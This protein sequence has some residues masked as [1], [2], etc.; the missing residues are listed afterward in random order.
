MMCRFGIKR[1]TKTISKQF[2][3][4]DMK[5]HIQTHINNCEVCMQSKPDL[6]GIKRYSLHISD[7]NP[8]DIISFDLVRKLP[9]SRE[10]SS[11]V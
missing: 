4:K 6:Q 9:R 3:W 10:P 11:S 2:F 1:T 7:T 5:T 8:I